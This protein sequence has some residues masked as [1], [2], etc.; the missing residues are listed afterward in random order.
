MGCNFEER[1]DGSRNTNVFVRGGEGAS[2]MGRNWRRGLDGAVLG[3]GCYKT[4]SQAC[5]FCLATNE[6]V[7]VWPVGWKCLSVR[8]YI[9]PRTRHKRYAS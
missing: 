4:I 8:R 1:A 3:P 5:L 7:P 2:G 6:I 9:D